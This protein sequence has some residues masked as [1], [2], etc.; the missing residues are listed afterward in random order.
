MFRTYAESADTH[1]DAEVGVP[2]FLVTPMWAFR[3]VLSPRKQ[4]HTRR[5]Q[6]Q[7]HTICSYALRCQS[8]RTRRA[9]SCFRLPV[10]IAPYWTRHTNVFCP[11]VAAAVICCSCCLHSNLWLLRLVRLLLANYVGQLNLLH[12]KPCLSHLAVARCAASFSSCCKAG[13]AWRARWCVVEGIRVCPTGAANASS[14]THVKPS[15]GNCFV[16]MLTIQQQQQLVVDL[17]THTYHTH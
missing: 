13:A 3:D 14:S 4:M 12:I 7:R 11:H 17:T 6:T 2:A 15:R 8:I 16:E 5:C 9:A 1:T 10:L